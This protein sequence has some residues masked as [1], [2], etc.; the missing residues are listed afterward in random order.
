MIRKQTWILLAVFVVL[1]AAVFYLQKNPLP[2]NKAD[3]TPSPTAQRLLL[4]GFQT[5]D[6]VFVSYKDAATELQLSNNGGKWVVLPDNKPVDVGKAEEVR[7]QIADMYVMSILPTSFTQASGGLA[8]P[9]QTLTFKTS[10]GKEAVLKV[11][12]TTPT[13]DGYYV[14]VDN[15]TPVVVEK[16]A[17]DTLIGQ[18]TISNLAPTPTPAPATTATSAVMPSAT[19]TP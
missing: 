4:A 2:V 1:L 6:I 3:I 14:Q 15:N 8:S 16:G 12:Q 11:G 9:K 19:A 17:L 13:G 5:Q 10:Q 18:M 7:A